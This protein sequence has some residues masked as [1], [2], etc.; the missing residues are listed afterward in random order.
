L[1]PEPALD[2]SSKVLEGDPPPGGGDKRGAIALAFHPNFT[3]NGRLFLFFAHDAGENGH[4]GNEDG[5]EGAMTLEEYA[6]GA[7]NDVFNPQATATIASIRKGT[8][9]SCYQHNGGSLELGLDGHLY[10]SMGDPPPFTDPGAEDPK[11]LL[12][13]ILRYDISGATVKPAG[14]YPNGDPAVYSIGLRNPYK[15]SFDRVTGYM[16]IGDVGEN[17]W[18]EISIQGPNDAHKNFGWPVREGKH[19]YRAGTCN[20]CIEPIAEHGH[21]NSDNAV[22]GGYVYRGSKIPAL[23]GT[24]IYGDNGSGTVRALQVKAGALVNGPMVMS[25]LKVGAGCFG[26]D[27]AGEIYACGYSEGKVFRFDPN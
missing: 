22:I 1:L 10:V 11:S 21:N 9:G 27:N 26:Q 2:I 13:K 3:E 8:C 23:Q 25:G 12:G 15:F 4:S 14:N 16:F 6:R 5:E 20:G 19:N 17:T 18:E 7:N 24:Y